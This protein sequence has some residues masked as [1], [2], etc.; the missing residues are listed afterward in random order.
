MEPSI[1]RSSSQWYVSA[2][3][4]KRRGIP[5]SEQIALDNITPESTEADSKTLF[6]FLNNKLGVPGDR[7]YM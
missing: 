4:L 6:T 5:C 3:S 7:G 2:E 1:L